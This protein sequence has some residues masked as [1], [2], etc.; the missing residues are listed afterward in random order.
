MQMP[1]RLP[2]RP[3]HPA[4]SSTTHR[5]HEGDAEDIVAEEE[6]LLLHQA[7]LAVRLDLLWRGA[8]GR[9]EGMARGLWKDPERGQESAGFTSF[10]RSLL[11]TRS[12]GFPVP[13]AAGKQV[14]FPILHELPCP[15]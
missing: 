4:W 2:T 5:V 7:S 13:L 3:P 6:Q 1:H 9:G 10:P 11:Q 14:A 8:E 15:V 12:P